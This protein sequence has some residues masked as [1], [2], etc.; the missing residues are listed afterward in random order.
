MINISSFCTPACS[1]HQSLA[2]LIQ[3]P[4]PNDAVVPQKPFFVEVPW[5]GLNV[6]EKL[7]T[8]SKSQSPSHPTGHQAL[9]TPVSM[10]INV[11]LDSEEGKGK[12]V[13]VGG[14]NCILAEY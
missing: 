2:T 3:S 14:I 8:H 13:G 7:E 12:S 9:S 10:L 1:L 5:P 4:S 6:R 11:I